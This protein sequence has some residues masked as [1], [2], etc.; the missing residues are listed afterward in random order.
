MSLISITD[1]IL[2]LPASN[3]PLSSDVVII[4]GEAYSWIYDVGNS[5]EARQVISSIQGRKNIIISHFHED[6]LGNLKKL[7]YDNIYCGEFTAKKVQFGIPVTSKISFDDIVHLD[8]FPIPSTH[9]KGAVGLQA[10]EK[11]AFVGD[12]VYPQ[13]K[14][15]RSAYNANTLKETIDCLESLKAHRLAVSHSPQF[16]LDKDSVISNL[17]QIYGKR[18]SGESFIFED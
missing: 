1:K 17:K 10:D 3:S 2:Y 7:Q 11:I 13:N 5:D 9:S 12:A 8:I 16:L 18:Q 6:H 14:G 15:G 4:H